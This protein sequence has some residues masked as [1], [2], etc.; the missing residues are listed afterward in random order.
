MTNF[1]TNQV[2]QFYV[3]DG[4]AEVKTP[5][6][7]NY[8][9]VE[10]KDADGNV[11]ALTDK[12]EN[13]M[14]GKLTKADALAVPYKEATITFN[15]DVNEGAPVAGQDYI[16]RVS[17]P[18]IG[19]VGAEA[20]TVKTAAARGAS[21]DEVYT[22]LAANLNKAFESDGV[23]VASVD[24]GL[25]I[26]QTDAFV[27]AYK[28]GLRPVKVVDFTV[29]A[30]TVVLDGE[31][32]N[33]AD[34]A[35]GASATT[36]P[37]G[38]KVADME[39]FAMGERGDQYR[40]VDYVNAI[41]TEYKVDPKGEY[42]VLTVHFAYKGYNQNSHKSEKD[43]IIVAAADTA[44][45]LN[46][47]DADGIADLETLAKAIRDAAGVDFTVLDPENENAKEEVLAATSDESVSES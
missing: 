16:V 2:M 4:T 42:D 23:L 25:V 47:L 10:F 34:V 15:A 17:Y 29:T 37:G 22:A 8:F 40:Y 32:V 39:Y 44:S 9:K 26:T 1:S 33:W 30:A 6:V 24:N 46:A 18:E 14:Y 28:R 45:E 13:V 41:D 21:A 3:L 43:L 36:V 31:E 11:T 35:Y 5:V 38:Y 20:W 27:K 7:G 12:I 19:G